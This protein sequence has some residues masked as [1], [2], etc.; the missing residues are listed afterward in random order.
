ML[1]VSD[2][3]RMI[4]LYYCFLLLM[5]N[6]HFPST[7]TKI[8]PAWHS[9]NTFSNCSL[10]TTPLD[11]VFSTSGCVKWTLKGSDHRLSQP[12]RH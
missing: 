3:V 2:K 4:N 12:Q 8:P 1:Y 9:F 6:C 11:S 10:E 7:P 5:Q